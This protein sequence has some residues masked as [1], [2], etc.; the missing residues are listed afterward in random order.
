VLLRAGAPARPIDPSA[1]LIAVIDYDAAGG[2]SVSG[3]AS[4][5]A[6]VE[7]TV[8]GGRPAKARADARGVYGRSLGDEGRLAAGAHTLNVSM[9]AGSENK[10][11]TFTAGSPGQ[12]FRAVRE[13]TG[14]RVDWAPPGGG[15]QST[16]VFMPPAAS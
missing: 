11:A 6:T 10:S 15:A 16:F 3:V 4:A 13:P 7:V 14:W 12:T 2:A 8:D 9:P 1:G 5:G